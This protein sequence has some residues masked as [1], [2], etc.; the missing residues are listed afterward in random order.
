MLD[1]QAAVYGRL[2]ADATLAGLLSSYDGGAAI[3]SDPVPDDLGITEPKP[4]C[5]I[6]APTDNEAADT[7][8]EDGRNVGLSIRL[9]AKPEGSTLPIDTAAEWVR[10]IIK[11]WPAGAVTGGQFISASVSGPVV[12]PTDDPSLV[13]RLVN[14]RLFFEED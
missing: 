9:Y 8:T 1:I 13:G 10:S 7:Y 14:A 6:S 5:V 4:I 11:S 12:G 3:V 2:N